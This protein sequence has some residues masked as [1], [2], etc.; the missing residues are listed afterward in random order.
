[1]ASQLLFP[2]E[3][4]KLRFQAV[5]NSSNNPVPT[6]KGLFDAIKTIYVKEGIPALYRGVFIN[7]AAGSLANSIFF[8][9]YADGKNRYN[10]DPNKPYSMTT[11][12]IS[13][14]AGICA[15]AITTPF[16]TVKTRLALYQE[17]NTNSIR[18]ITQVAKDM[19]TKEG[20][21]SFYRGFIPSIFMSS[22][23]V[24]QMFSYEVLSHLS[25]YDSG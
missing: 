7:I 10:F 4:V 13:Y 11:M 22:Y 5:N 19:Y 2:L 6:Y 16:W 8:Y 9:V 18:I 1:M 21:K 23:G 12:L 24:I 14:R 25:G 17:G 20:I 15:M 3:N